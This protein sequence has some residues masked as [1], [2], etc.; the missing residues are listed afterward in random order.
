MRSSTTTR[1][2]TR[3]QAGHTA[4]ASLPRASNLLATAPGRVSS[5]T[6]CSTPAVRPGP[7]A[8]NTTPPLRPA[9]PRPSP[10][11]SSVRTVE[12]AAR[13]PDRHLDRPCSLP[14]GTQRLGCSLV[15]DP[16][17]RERVE[18]GNPGRL[19]RPGSFRSR[20]DNGSPLDT[21]PRPAWRPMV[22]RSLWSPSHGGRPM[23]RPL[24]RSS[25]STVH[26]V[27]ARRPRA[28]GR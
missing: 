8:E 15:Q 6:A 23:S 22:G 19:S 17:V 3:R 14:S 27:H 20:A 7:D 12:R 18:N 24:S 9:G 25:R 4:T 1:C 10:N 26:E 28:S 21:Y 13:P 11:P 16:R 2:C 5:G